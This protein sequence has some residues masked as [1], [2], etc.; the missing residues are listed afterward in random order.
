MEHCKIQALK[1]SDLKRLTGIKRNTF[2]KMLEILTKAEVIKKKQGGQPSKLSIPERLVL[3]LEYFREH[4]TYF[5]IANSR[6]I[7]ETTA[8]RIVRWVE[9]TLIESGVFNNLQSSISKD[10][11]YEAKEIEEVKETE[12]TILLVDATE[13][14]VNRPKNK[15]KQKKFIQVKRKNT[16]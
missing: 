12:T 4:R 11:D 10:I 13:T 5:H 2:N 1:D 3:T 14:P 9:N 8:I 7:N 16:Q 6:N 15:E